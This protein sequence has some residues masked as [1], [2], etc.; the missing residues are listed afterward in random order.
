MKITAIIKK[1][2]R[3]SYMYLCYITRPRNEKNIYFAS[4]RGQ[5]S[6]NPRAISEC[7]HRMA[8][9]VKIV[10]MVMPQFRQYVPDY[11]TI[12]PPT[13]RLALKAQAQARVW[14][15]NYIYRKQFG[16][17]KGR[18]NFY[19]QT[20][21]GDRGLKTIGYLTDYSKGRDYNG[22]DM[23]D[24]DLFMAAS[25]Y[26]V[27]KARQGFLYDGEIIVEGMPRNDKLVNI[28][29]YSDE[30]IEVRKCLGI[31]NDVKV[32][33]YAPTFRDDRSCQQ[34]A[35][36]IAASIANLEAKGKK[37]ICLVRSHSLSKGI[38]VGTDSPA[39][40][41]VT[42]YPDM[43]DLLLIADLLITD[44]SSCAGDFL[45]TG[46]PVVLA[47]FD[48]E[49]Y[50]AQGRPLW[51]NP[52]EAGYLVAKNQD[53]LNHILANLYS[54]DHR[55]IADKVN[56]FYETKETGQSSEAIVRRIIQELN[57]N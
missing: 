7:L 6:D 35:I 53:E 23:S 49:E 3:T 9:D 40:L 29:R 24:C 20:W 2:I 27:R 52:K 4:F 38:S 8:P 42:S 11:V 57:K 51:V 13:P 47:H 32:L 54:Y 14:V 48:K 17:Y 30:A 55:A 10:W 36:D 33:L 34:C 37:W 26:G 45:L 39:Y 41:D 28:A 22:Y 15:L 5:Y 21:H 46:K 56:R 50:E 12:V 16:V 1:W 43:A 19:I 25:D 18:D 44:Y 31:G